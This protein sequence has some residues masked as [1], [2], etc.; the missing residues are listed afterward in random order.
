M[1]EKLAKQTAVYGISTILGRFLSYALTPIY[2]RIFGTGEYGIVTDVYAL[3]PF[4][5]VVLNLGM[6]SGYFRFAAKAEAIGGDVKAAK[7]RLFATTWGITSLVALL[8]F[9]AVYIL[10]MPVAGLMGEVYVEN[11]SYIV[12]VAA[13]VMFDVSCCI[14]FSRLRQQGDAGRFVTLK[15]LN[16]VLQV[17]FALIF[18]ALGLFDTDFGVGWAFMA[19]LAASIITWIAVL[20]STEA[21]LPCIDPRILSAVLVY[22]LPLLI[23]GIAGTANELVD[24]QLIKYLVP[25]DAMGQLGI[26]GAICKIAVVMTLF[27]QMYRYA[28]EPFF[29]SNFRKDDFL[30]MNAAAMK[31]YVIVAMVIFIGIGL[32]KDLFALIVGPR[33]RQGIHILPIILAGNVLSGMWLNLSFWYKREEKTGLAIWITFSG[34][35][36]ALAAGFLLVPRYGY[37]GAAWGRLVSEVVMVAVS[38]TLNRLLYPTP[39]DLR[40]IALYLVGGTA[41][42]LFGERVVAAYTHG[43]A[44]YVVDTALLVLFT[45][46]AVWRE[47]I[48]IKGLIMNIVRRR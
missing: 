19:N 26:Y 41:I 42:Y 48:D 29:L 38:F 40:G 16:I 14:P 4:A 7:R 21:V 6:E 24:R 22:S 35:A 20:L 15:L 33:F 13:I 3:I 46:I 45:A 18:W 39:Y 37:E 12:I 5:L 34:L 44:M 23:S 47:N 27:T 36:A 11:P 2:T 25:D 10:R 31:Y 28:A 8:F 30:E 1:L 17:A 9:G 43:A 32:F